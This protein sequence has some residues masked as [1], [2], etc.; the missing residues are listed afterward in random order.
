[1]SVM[2]VADETV[3]KFVTN[4]VHPV[5]A[6]HVCGHRDE[7]LADVGSGVWI[8]SG[9]ECETD[10][11]LAVVIERAVYVHDFENRSIGSELRFHTF[12][13]CFVT[14]FGNAMGQFGL[15]FGN[16]EYFQLG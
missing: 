7:Q 15:G 5:V 13:S 3:Q 1:M 11:L 9:V 4:G 16:A 14:H 10:H 2:K 12:A 6:Y 8:E